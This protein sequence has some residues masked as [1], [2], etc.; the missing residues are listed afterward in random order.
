MAGATLVPQRGARRLAG[1]TRVLTLCAVLWGLFLMHGTA[2]LASGCHGAGAVMTAMTGSAMPTTSAS[3]VPDGGH[4]MA[5]LTLSV[6]SAAQVPQ[7]GKITPSDSPA[8]A[9]STVG[10]SSGATVCASLRPRDVP[11]GVSPTSLA[12]AAVVVPAPASAGHTAVFCRACRPPGPPG[13]PLP[14]FLGVSRT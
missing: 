8:A 13:L 4:A 14:L 1:L 12:G 5:T 10:A 11:V 6:K 2:P 3:A 9:G 7:A